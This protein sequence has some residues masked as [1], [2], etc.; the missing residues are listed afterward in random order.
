ML[1]AEHS[2]PLLTPE[3]HEAVVAPSA[4]PVADE[5]LFGAAADPMFPPPSVGQ[6]LSAA[7]AQLPLTPAVA[8]EPVVEPAPEPAPIP[9]RARPAD[10]PEY[11][12]VA[13]VELHFT[14][15]E[16]RIGVKAGTRSFAEFQ[17]L[18]GILL[19]DLRSVRGL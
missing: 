1:A 2:A 7:P 13:P 9:A 3:E 10:V 18:A 14:V 15:G 4:P 8:S 19:Q 16:G 5:P 17:R 12:L 11:R 6:V